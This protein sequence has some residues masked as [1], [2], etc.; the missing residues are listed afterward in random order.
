MDPMSSLLF[1]IPA[2]VQHE[3]AE[4]VLPVWA[5]PVIAA[6]VFALLAIVTW[7]FRDV[8]HRHHDRVAEADAH[9]DAHH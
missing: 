8:S 3:L 1:S 2:E 9:Q 7:S 4:L 5:F 6:G